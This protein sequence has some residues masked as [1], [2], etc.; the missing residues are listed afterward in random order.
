MMQTQNQNCQMHCWIY[1]IQ[2]ISLKQIKNDWL[3]EDTLMTS[4]SKSLVRTYHKVHKVFLNSKKQMKMMN[5]F[6][7]KKQES[8]AQF[9]KS[10]INKYK[11]KVTSFSSCNSIFLKTFIDFLQNILQHI[12]ILL[13]NFMIKMF[14]I[15]SFSFFIL[16]SQL[17]LQFY[18]MFISVADTAEFFMFNDKAVTDFLEQLNDL[19]EKHDIVEDD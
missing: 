14:F 4:D 13:N 11:K 10:C 8:L 15:N 19:Y 1:E 17:I 2:Q 6:C 3:S 16:I 7:K 5:S 9:L 12:T 18:H